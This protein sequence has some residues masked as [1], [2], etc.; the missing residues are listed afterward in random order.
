[1]VLTDIQNYKVRELPSLSVKASDFFLTRDISEYFSNAGSQTERHPRQLS[2]RTKESL[3]CS[4]TEVSQKPA[5]TPIIM[6]DAD[7][8]I[9]LFDPLR[10]AA[11]PY[12][13][14]YLLL[15]IRIP[16]TPER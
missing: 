8:R 1:M 6:A 2:L 9:S 14:H 16:D 15:V 3:S 4:K 13:R 12:V 11:D 5:Q 7:Y 10:L